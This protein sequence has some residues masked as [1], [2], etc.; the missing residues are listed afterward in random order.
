VPA[1]DVLGAL[2]G[3]NIRGAFDRRNRDYP[4]HMVRDA[5]L[6]KNRARIAAVARKARASE[7]ARSAA[8]DRFCSAHGL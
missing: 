4:G 2:A 3:M 6:R 8:L 7:A 1:A 5:E